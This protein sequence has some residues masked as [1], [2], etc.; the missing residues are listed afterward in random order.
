MTREDLAFTLEQIA[1]LLELK[2]EN[3]FKIRAYRTGADTV[4]QF[5][6]DIY[7]KARND[8]LKGIKGIG[9][10]LQQKL[11]ELASTGELEFYEKLRK[12]FP[13]SLF[14]L[15]KIQGLGPKKIKAVYEKL[16]VDSVDKLKEVCESRQ[17]R[18]AGRFR[19]EVRGKI[20]R[21]D[22]VPRGERRVFPVG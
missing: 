9:D 2:G 7:E 12:E 16:G 21:I 14:D 22:S 1:L 8:D 5:S 19:E 17:D 13:E 20:A 11:H 6:G 15:F 10:A 4:R 3:P 18:G